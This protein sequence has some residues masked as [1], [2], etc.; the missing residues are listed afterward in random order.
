MSD[1][2]TFDQIS[3][4]D[5]SLVGGKALK[6]ASMWRAG[7][8]V[9]DGFCISSEAYR[10]F[11]SSAMPDSL[12]SEIAEACRSLGDSMVA[13][14]SSATAE[15]GAAASFAGQ[16]ETS[17]GVSGES[18][19]CE[20]VENCWRSLDS[21]RARAYREKQSIGETAM[22]VVV[23]RLI[24]AE[25]AGVLFTRD[26]MRPESDRMLIESSWGLGETV[27]SGKVMPDRFVVNRSEAKVSERQLGQK[28]VE[29]TA[30][31]ETPV[32]LEKQ[33]CFSLTDEQLAELAVLARRIEEHFGSPQD[34]EW[35]W[36]G[37]HAWI[38]QARP[39][40]TAGPREREA[41]RQEEIAALRAKA[42][43]GGTAWVRFNL[44]EVLSA[45]TPMTWAIVRRFL[46]GSGGYGQMYADL[47][48][49]PDPSL[50]DECGYDLICG[51]PYLN[52]SREPRMQWRNLPFRHDFAKLKEHPEKAAYSQLA[53]RQEGALFFLKLRTAWTILKGGRKYQASVRNFAENFR[54]KTIPALKSETTAAL[55]EDWSQL[56]PASLLQKLE[57]WTNRT[58]VQ[59][60]R[61]SLKATVFAA[62]SIATVKK[63]LEK[64]LGADRAQSAIAELTVG[65][66]PD[67]D[68][69]LTQAL[70]DVAQ[71]K[72]DRVAFVE[73]FGH[74][75][76]QEMELAAPRWAEDSN[77]LDQLISSPISKSAIL[78]D[79][80]AISRIADEARLNI[81][82]RTALRREL[83]KLRAFLALR[84]TGKHYLMRG[85]SLIRRAIVELD[86]R[87]S[88]SGG[89]FFLVPA[90]LPELIKGKNFRSTID[91][92]RKRRAIALGLEAPPTL[93][94]DDLEAIDRPIPLPHGATEMTGVS[95]SAGVAEGPAIVLI[96]PN[97]Q[98]PAQSDYI[99]VC[100][101]TNPSWVP[102]F[103]K[104]KGL[105]MET[106]G[107]LSHG[108][109]VAREF[110]IPA[111][112]G[113]SGVVGQIKTGQRLRVDG[114]RGSIAIL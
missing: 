38:L 77:A 68:A 4:N 56:D 80:T 87:F 109:I 26:P 44:A 78:D 81:H 102:L 15:D 32:P 111:V 71:R 65:V 52:L 113:F 72:I 20:A 28:T 86:R 103:A 18:Q 74:R 13:V 37:G 19:V 42:E 11:H 101:S 25:A 16:Q 83:D 92:R 59:F 33:S 14:R 91:A 47:G 79:P 51:Q 107:I 67:P 88:L 2:R 21:D 66:R 30:S 7:L 55:A 9:P 3:D 58:L 10:R 1:I 43:P 96:D 93:F 17:L 73:Q 49:P 41:I 50:A 90:E 57:F 8:P 98:V 40:T 12:K 22:A 112:A 110:G 114:N 75:G 62:G 36:A 54:S 29:R 63:I 99:L 61:D 5:G 84:E 34:V 108:A 23:Q 53:F 24:P 35:A 106:G 69:D 48:F 64:P 105:V 27:V 97:V 95:L 76:S 70:R 39:I 94:S 60:A 104:A 89:V 100:P 82:Q 85:Y 31:G 46:S 45:P 6:L